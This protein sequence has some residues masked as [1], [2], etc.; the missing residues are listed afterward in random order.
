VRALS[1][2]KAGALTALA[3]ADTALAKELVHAL[4]D[5]DAQ[6]VGGADAA[7]RFILSNVLIPFI[8][9]SYYI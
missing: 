9:Y 8:L 4:E 2:L 7:I 1:A 5:P 3:D 6:I